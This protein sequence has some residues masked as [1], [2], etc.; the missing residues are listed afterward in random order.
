MTSES[1]EPDQVPSPKQHGGARPGS[2]RK[3]LKDLAETAAT[4][5][6]R[7]AYK[8]WPKG[9]AVTPYGRALGQGRVYEQ[10]RLL[11]RAAAPRMMAG[12][13][14]LAETAEDERVRSVSLIAVL[15]RA[16]LRPIETDP[17]PDIKPPFNPRLYTPEEL[18]TIETAL[19]LIK[20][21]RI[22]TNPERPGC[23]VQSNR[24]PI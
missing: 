19:K 12:L 6:A 13:I 3:R 24:G 22:D 9:I 5:A 16:G 23:G 10:A 7:R 20:E 15:D 21:R 11:A 2:G 18:A 8:R 4:P 14:K 17:F 1:A